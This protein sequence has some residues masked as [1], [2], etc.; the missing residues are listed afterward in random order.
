[1]GFLGRF[2]T[3][4]LGKPVT[5][6]KKTFNLE[7]IKKGLYKILFD[8]NRI[9]CIKGINKDIKNDIDNLRQHV[10][11][12]NKKI[13]LVNTFLK[14]K[15]MKDLEKIKAELQK[16]QEIVNKEYDEDKQESLY[17]I[18]AIESI[19]EVI[20]SEKDLDIE[21]EEYNIR[22]DLKQL[23]KDIENL[24]PCLVRQLKFFEMPIEKQLKNIKSLL[25]DIKEEAA[26]IGYERSLLKDL[27]KQI[28]KFQIDAIMAPEESDS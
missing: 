21:D 20:S 28:D 13:E 6:K 11:D 25:F 3:L 8:D 9:G 19:N 27:N 16:I 23:K 14:S 24:E 12:F 22:Q 10:L 15:D 4:Q 26:I 17:V 7:K 1:M 2:F 5:E 18:K